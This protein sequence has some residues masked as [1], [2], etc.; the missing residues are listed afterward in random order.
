MFTHHRHR[1]I[2]A[3]AAAAA[4]LTTPAA[5][6]VAQPSPTAGTVRNICS[7]HREAPLIAPA[8]AASKAEVEALKRLQT[9]PSMKCAKVE[10]VYQCLSG[11]TMHLTRAPCRAGSTEASCCK[12][13][14]LKVNA[15][16][17]PEW[18]KAKKSGKFWSPGIFLCKCVEAP[19][20]LRLRKPR[21]IRPR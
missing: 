7:N 13:V 1:L 21:T 2:L 8:R 3:F 18:D 14:R 17:G 19:R 20:R 4:L 12:A 10:Y 9:T 16:C 6:Q 5:A 11:Q 15:I